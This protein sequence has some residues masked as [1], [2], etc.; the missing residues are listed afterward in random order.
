MK[1]ERRSSIGKKS[2]TD[3]KQSG[4]HVDLERLGYC[5]IIPSEPNN[6]CKEVGEQRGS[7]DTAWSGNKHMH[8]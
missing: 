2:L 1:V 3:K 7:A 5:G 4:V 8:E 6:P